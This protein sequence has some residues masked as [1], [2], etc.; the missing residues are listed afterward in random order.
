MLGSIAG[1]LAQRPTWV[2]VQRWMI[3]GVLT[4]LGVKMGAEG[5]GGFLSLAETCASIQIARIRSPTSPQNMPLD[6]LHQ[7]FQVNLQLHVAVCG[8]GLA[9]GWRYATARGGNSRLRTTPLRTVVVLASRASAL[10]SSAAPQ[11]HS[12]IH[13]HAD[14]RTAKAVESRR[15]RRLANRAQVVREASAHVDGIRVGLSRAERDVPVGQA[16][17][18]EARK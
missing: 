12:S 6:R 14:S 1:F 9:F 16:V 5:S 3:V 7:N 18:R 15:G 2:A 13:H 11:T 8:V 4:G 17:F 10:P